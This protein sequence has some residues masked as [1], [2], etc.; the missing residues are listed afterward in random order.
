M[1]YLLKKNKIL[2]NYY[3]IY[4]YLFF[5]IQRNNY[6]SF[7]RKIDELRHDTLHHMKIVLKTLKKYSEFVANTLQTTY[8]NSII[9]GTNNVIKCI[10]RFSFGYRRFSNF[11]KR[12]M[13]IKEL[14][15]INTCNI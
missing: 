14:I 11:R 1:D 6:Q 3:S 5:S 2:S 12:S 7:F 10:K 13:I 4:Q 15:N 8:A 9:E